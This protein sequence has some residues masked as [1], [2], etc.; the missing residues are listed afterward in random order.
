[1]FSNTEIPIWG[2]Y[3]LDIAEAVAKRASCFRAHVG[4]VIVKDRRILSTGYNGAPAGRMNCYERGTCYREDNNIPSGTRLEECYAAGAHAET[5][6]IINAARFGVAIDGSV[7][8]LVGHDS[9]CAT[10]QV[11]ILNAGIEKVVIRKRD[12]KKEF[13]IPKQDFITHAILDAY[14]L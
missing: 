7:L 5:N 1:M 14:F 12:G 3:F 11:A 10:C 6:A 9:C 8:Y 4:C 13:I 2:D